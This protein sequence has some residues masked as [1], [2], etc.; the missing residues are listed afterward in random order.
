M[1]R[2]KHTA[3]KQPKE[4]RPVGMHEATAGPSQRG[5]RSCSQC[6][7]DFRSLSSLRRHCIIK[8]GATVKGVAVSVTQIEKTRRGGRHQSRGTTDAPPQ[9]DSARRPTK[10]SDSDRPAHYPTPDKAERKPPRQ[11]VTPSCTSSTVATSRRFAPVTRGGRHRSTLAAVT[12]TVGRSTLTSPLSAIVR[13]RPASARSVA[14]DTEHWFEPP[15]VSMTTILAALDERP[16][17][18]AEEIAGELRNR[19]GLPRSALPGLRRNVSAVVFGFRTA[20][21]RL[22]AAAPDSA[23]PESELRSRT[24][25][26]NRQLHQMDRRP[27]FRPGEI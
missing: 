2:T 22:A 19:L 11:S 9:R 5:P 12:S 24:L 1:A 26:L 8:H 18:S 6:D 23:M 15:T 21:A 13:R 25:E 4:H 17:A 3:R 20:T 16:T 14:T 10:S 27:P 7:R